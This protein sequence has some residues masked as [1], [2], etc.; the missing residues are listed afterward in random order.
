[1]FYSETKE[2]RVK[3]IDILLSTLGASLPENMLPVEG[4]G[5][6]VIQVN[7]TITAGQDF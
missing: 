1:M 2:Q 4:F 5:D 3:F 6:R 7:Q